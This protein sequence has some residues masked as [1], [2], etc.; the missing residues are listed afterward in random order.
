M[1][2]LTCKQKREPQS[3]EHHAVSILGSEGYTH[4]KHYL[5]Y[6]GPIRCSPGIPEGLSFPVNTNHLPKETGFQKGSVYYFVRI[7]RSVL[8]SISDTPENLLN[9]KQVRV[10][11]HWKDKAHSHTV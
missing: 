7:L 6:A 8:Q 11:F 2:L 1:K 10:S 9:L 4:V 5:E 3:T